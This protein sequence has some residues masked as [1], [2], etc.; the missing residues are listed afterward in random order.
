MSVG[1]YPKAQSTQNQVLAVQRLI[2]RG[3]DSQM[4]STTIPNN[5]GSVCA[6]IL[7]PVNAIVSAVSK[8]D[9]TGVVTSY[10]VS[11]GACV[12]IDS[13]GGLSGTNE[14]G[15]A[16]SDQGAIKLTALASLAA[17]DTVT[18]DYIVQPHL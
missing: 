15:M 10:S 14:Q 1:Y 17:D 13:Q 6:L 11:G 3:Q 4:Y 12:I 5:T 16:V 18:I 9:S 2:F 8:V 7:E